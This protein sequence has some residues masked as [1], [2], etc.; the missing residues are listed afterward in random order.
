MLE[1][2]SLYLEETAKQKIQ[3]TTLFNYCINSLG[4]TSSEVIENDAAEAKQTQKLLIAEAADT[5]ISSK[6][7]T[8]KPV[9][10]EEFNKL[11][12]ERYTPKGVLVS[13]LQHEF[14]VQI[15]GR[16]DGSIEEYLLLSPI[17]NAL[18]A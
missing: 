3:F 1:N 2:S 16:T 18:P 13:L 12:D 17:P 14:S 6:Y 7:K 9:L 5:I 8:Y 11:F 10:S 15:K 4:L